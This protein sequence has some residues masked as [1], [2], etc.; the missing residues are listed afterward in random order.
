[1][2]KNL[3]VSFFATSLALSQAF[4]MNYSQP[5]DNKTQQNIERALES[6]I[7]PKTV[8]FGNQPAQDSNQD[9][10]IVKNSFVSSIKNFVKTA[11]SLGADTTIQFL[12]IPALL[13]FFLAIHEFGHY[14]IAKLFAS[15]SNPEIHLFSIASKPALFTIGDLNV[16]TETLMYSITLMTPLLNS[17][18]EACMIA[19]GPSAGIFAI[20]LFFFAKAC[21]Q[22][23]KD[24]KNL[25]R[26]FAFACAHGHTPFENLLAQKDLGSWQFLVRLLVTLCS[27]SMMFDHIVYGFFPLVFANSDLKGDGWRLWQ[28]FFNKDQYFRYSR[29]EI[30]DEITK[31]ITQDNLLMPIATEYMNKNI[32]QN[33]NFI[34]NIKELISS[35]GSNWCENLHKKDLRVGKTSNIATSLVSIIGT[36]AILFKTGNTLTTFMFNEKTVFHAGWNKVVCPTVHV[37]VSIPSKVIATASAFW[38]Y[39][40]YKINGITPTSTDVVQDKKN[41]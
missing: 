8:V 6:Y 26:A 3:F 21:I 4:C 38:S 13:A 40:S 10:N 30:A 9:S 41:Q 23:Y 16:H 28:H 19:A 35:K 27:T 11:V 20:Y 15:E 29:C 32:F 33:Q 37:V 12:S 18:M 25:K 36:L 14:S 24:T 2:K 5:N 22:K 39:V 1:M 31:N 17:T 7:P 34:K